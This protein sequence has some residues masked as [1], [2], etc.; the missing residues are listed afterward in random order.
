MFKYLFIKFGTAKKNILMCGSECLAGSYH[1]SDADKQTYTNCINR[2][3]YSRRIKI[4]V[5][6]MRNISCTMIVHLTKMAITLSFAPIKVLAHNL[7]CLFF[8]SVV[9]FDFSKTN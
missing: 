6:K 5:P 2:H 3:M 9:V 1:A 8:S 7:I 4:C